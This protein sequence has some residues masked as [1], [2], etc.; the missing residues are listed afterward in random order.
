MGK[1]SFV[2]S[3]RTGFVAT[4]AFK[5]VTAAAVAGTFFGFGSSMAMA[6]PE[7]SEDAQPGAVQAEATTVDLAQDVDIAADAQDAA[8]ESGWA[9]SESTVAVKAPAPAP[10]PASQ[11]GNAQQESTFSYTPVPYNGSLGAQ[12]LGIARQGIG[13]PYVWAGST[14]SGWDCSG[15]V[16]WI[17]AQ[18]GRS[19]GHGADIIASTYSIISPSEAQPGDL[20]W[21]PG[22]HIA[23]YAGNGQIIGAQN[24]GQGT[25][26]TSLYGSYQ[27]VRVS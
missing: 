26:Q 12:I 19:V 20:V 18:T 22:Q 11:A 8:P 1:H 4:P 14:P 7:A 21:W 27:F 9:F 10:A 17:L 16:M 23:V 24:P 15:F 5:G 3:T 2:K 13:V 25:V 6:A